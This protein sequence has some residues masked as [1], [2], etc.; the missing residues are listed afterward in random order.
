MKKIVAMLLA[1][2]MVFSLCACGSKDDVSG[3]VSAADKDGGAS[4]SVTQTSEPSPEPEEEVEPGN[5]VGGRYENEFLGIGCELDDN[6]VYATQEELAEMIGQTAEMFDEESA[7][8]L[9]KADMFYDMLAASEDGL[10]SIN[11][12]IQN[13]G[14]LYGAVL[15]E[16]EY[17]ELSTENLEAQLGSAG[18]TDISW[19]QITPD[20]AGQQRTGL[21]ISSKIQGN[22]YYT[23]QVYI[24][25]GS[26]MAV[27]SFSSF[28]EDIGEELMANFFAL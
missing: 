9:K 6:W 11:V 21:H 28:A 15:S 23:T 10:V 25:A 2:V 24:K 1:L 17:V 14:V 19:E 13:L 18:F 3:S 20:F 5:L 22:D 12:V 8:Q 27:I 26:Y 4:G 16:E 7:E